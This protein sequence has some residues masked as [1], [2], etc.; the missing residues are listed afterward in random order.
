MAS[1]RKK[2]GELLLEDG[3]ITNDQLTE[4]LNLQK[5][6]TEKKPVGELLVQLGYLSEEGLAL[7]LSKKLG[8]KYVSLSDKSLEIRFEQELDKL[9]DEKFARSNLVLPMS[10]TEKSISIAIWDPLDFGVVDSIKKVTGLDVIIYCSPKKDILDGID[11]LYL[12]KG[13]PSAGGKGSA[14]GAMGEKFQLKRTVEMDQLKLMAADAPVIKLVNQVL[15]QAV[16]EKASDIHL[17]PNENGLAIRYRIDGILYESEPPPKD[18]GLPIIS[19]IKILSRLDIAEKRLPQDGGFMMRIE[20]RSI[21]FRVSSIPVIHGE[22]VVMRVL[23]KEN[24]NFS[25]SSIGLSKEGLEKV[26]TAI[27][28]PYGLIFLT[29]PTGSGKT[30]TLYCI[31]SELRSPQKNIITIEDPVEYRINGVNQVQAMPNIGL[32]FARGLRAFLRQD[33]DI[34]MVGEVRDLET[35]EICVRSALVGRLVLSTLHT[36]DSVGSVYRLIDLGVEPF[37]VSSTL[38]MVIAQR[39]VRRLCP[40]C[41][42]VAKLSQ[43]LIEKYGLQGSTIYGPK[44]CKSCRNRGFSGRLPIFE[45]MTVDE[46][47]QQMIERRDDAIKIKNA[48]V[49]KGMKTLRD[50]GLDK[51]K[52]GLTSLNEVI[53][54]TRE[55]E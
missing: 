44:G 16:R 42:E 43:K 8:A 17:E 23:D 47:I 29:G 4:A 27:K 19:R 46:E 1:E 35:A 52:A 24:L 49:K 50:D 51:V 37:L 12:Q 6:G 15:H 55:T 7:T 54:T 33:P 25:L 28:K 53:I 31:L 38:L 34:I 30:T 32:D 45:I 40:D 36:N 2:L 9:I 13:A 48:L 41:K 21:D 22:K 10:K 14:T 5:R 3:L 39:L 18:L 26:S 20:G 11:D